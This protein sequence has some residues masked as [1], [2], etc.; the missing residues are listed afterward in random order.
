[1]ACLSDVTIDC[2]KLNK[3]VYMF[4]LYRIVVD[5]VLNLH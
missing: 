3:L 2:V 1:M 5:I 4:V